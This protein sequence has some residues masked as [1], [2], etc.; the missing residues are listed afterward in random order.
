MS[1]VITGKGLTTVLTVLSGGWFDAVLVYRRGAEVSWEIQ[2][3]SVQV[4]YLMHPLWTYLTIWNFSYV[5]FVQPRKP[6]K[7][8]ASVCL[9]LFFSLSLFTFLKL[10]DSN[11]R[12]HVRTAASGGKRGIA[13]KEIT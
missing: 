5:T 11:L 10:H 8:S 2:A 9:A 12:S 4:R 13:N 3:Q 1:S 6:K 7:K